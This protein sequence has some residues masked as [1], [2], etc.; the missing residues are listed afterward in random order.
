MNKNLLT[1]YFLIVSISLMAQK[2]VYVEYDYYNPANT[3]V[4]YIGNNSDTVFHNN[5]IIKVKGSTPCMVKLTNYNTEALQTTTILR[6][7][8]NVD[9]ISA[10]NLSSFFNTFSALTNPSIGVNF[11]NLLPTSRGQA[12]SKLEMAELY[13]NFDVLQSIDPDDALANLVKFDTIIR[14]KLSDIN[15]WKLILNRLNQLRYN[16]SLSEKDTKKQSQELI[17]TFSIDAPVVFN[18]DIKARIVVRQLARENTD[19][20]NF[21]LASLQKQT[22]NAPTSRG[23]TNRLDEFSLAK[24]NI[25]EYQKYI[26]NDTEPEVRQVMDN[27]VSSYQA[28]Q[29]NAFESRMTLMIDENIDLLQLKMYPI[30]EKGQRL[31]KEPIQSQPFFVKMPGSISILNTVGISLMKFNEQPLSYSVINSKI[32][33]TPSDRILPSFA[34]YMHFVGRGRSAI[35]LG[36]HFGVGVPLT[37]SKSVNFQMGPTLVIGMQNAICLN[38]GIIAGRVQRLGG[39]FSVGDNYTSTATLPTFNRYEMGYQ[40]GLSF[41][42]AGFLKR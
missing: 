6:K 18:D 42:M 19:Y 8:T 38:F 25:K 1:F 2:A 17:S 9:S 36:G 11:S 26:N 14:N 10:V 31:S 13:P 32:V 24:E 39:G 16:T 27:I 12:H 33:S 20:L 29:S 41:N 15:R 21:A 40:V 30:N 23:I 4:G 7:S 22:E 35:K 28:I 34:F 3:R 37:E 5:R